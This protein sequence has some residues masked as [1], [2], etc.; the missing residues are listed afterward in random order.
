MHL[1]PKFRTRGRARKIKAFR[2]K[3]KKRS[4]GSSFMILS[5]HSKVDFHKPSAL[6]S[7]PMLIIGD[8]IRQT[9]RRSAKTFHIEMTPYDDLWRSREQ[10]ITRKLLEIRENKVI[11][12]GHHSL[13]SSNCFNS[14]FEPTV[15]VRKHL[16]PFHQ[17]LIAKRHY[18]MRRVSIG[19]SIFTW[20]V[21]RM[22]MWQNAAAGL[23]NGEWNRH[24]YQNF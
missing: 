8:N 14:C 6:R 15:F 3:I 2:K 20:M 21:K 9:S 10:Q 22:T 7:F 23:N 4:S 12:P 19:L 5:S 16:D 13:P 17:P 18:L 1:P 24:E 11:A